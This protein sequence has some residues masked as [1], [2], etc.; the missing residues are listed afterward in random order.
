MPRFL[1]IWRTSFP[2]LRHWMKPARVCRS[3]IVSA[4]LSMTESPRMRPCFFRS[5]GMR[6]IPARTASRVLRMVTSRPLTRILPASFL[7][8]RR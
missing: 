1:T 7:G 6:A 4:E 5:S 3:K 2:M 8:I